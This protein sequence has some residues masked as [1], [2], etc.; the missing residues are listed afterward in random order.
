MESFS[1]ENA[2]RHFARLYVL[3]SNAIE[4]GFTFYS[5]DFNKLKYQLNTGANV[6][7]FSTPQNYW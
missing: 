7:N 4:V 5:C 1:E 2:K 6:I 3:S